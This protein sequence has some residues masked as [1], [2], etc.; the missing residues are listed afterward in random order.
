[1]T[2]IRTINDKHQVDS[3]NKQAFGGV[4]IL[5]DVVVGERSSVMVFKVLTPFNSSSL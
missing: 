5:M 4:I 1:M 2:Y 3:E